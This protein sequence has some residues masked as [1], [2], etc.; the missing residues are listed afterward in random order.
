MAALGY[1]QAVRLVPL[2]SHYFFQFAHRGEQPRFERI[3]TLTVAPV[4]AG[5]E[6]QLVFSIRDTGI[7][8]TPAQLETVFQPFKQ[9][10]SSTTRHYGGTGLGLSICQRLAGLMGGTLGVT[11]E[12]GRGTTFTFTVTLSSGNRDDV[13]QGAPFSPEAGMDLRDCRVLVAEDHPI[14]QQIIREVLE[15]AGAV[16]TLVGD[17]RE[18]VTA[19]GD[20]CGKFD[21]VLMD[22]QM[23]TMDGLEATRLIRGECSAW[24]LHI[25]AMTAHAMTEEKERCLAAGMDDHL[26]KP[27]RPQEVYACLARWFRPAAATPPTEVEK[28]R[29][30]NGDGPERLPG[31]DV[32][33]GVVNCCG[34]P[35]FYRQLVIQL[36]NTHGDDVDKL[37]DQLSEALEEIR[38]ALPLLVSTPE[39]QAKSLNAPD[40]ERVTPLI[41]ELLEL[42]RHRKLAALDVISSLTTELSE[43]TAA[44]DAQALQE[45]VEAL[46]FAAAYGL[47]ERLAHQLG[48]D[49]SR[50][51]G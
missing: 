47:V 35:L 6:D 39:E 43:T 32:S 20:A 15:Q 1:F 50:R 44:T 25:I 29:P 33:A 24:R 42:T 31:F 41:N 40:V 22:I 14:N 21:V 36:I 12:P 4:S 27:L 38:G 3:V 46:D 16:V 18:A 51:T 26:T 11:S 9:A 19:V 7:G 45:K 2:L 48:I 37:L 30:E 5:E 10:E 28:V 23:P 17:G 34:D 8:M 13:T 49:Y